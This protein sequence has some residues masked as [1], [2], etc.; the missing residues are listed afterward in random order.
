MDA[1]GF[2][3]GS[4]PD[5]QAP[6][7]GPRRG[8]GRVVPGFAAA[9]AVLDDEDFNDPHDPDT[10]IEDPENILVDD[11]PSAHPRGLA[12]PAVTGVVVAVGEA[13]AWVGRGDGLW[14]LP[15]SGGAERIALPSAGAVRQLASSADGRVIVAAL[16]GAIVRSDDGGARFEPV[17]DAPAGVSRLVV[18]GGGRAYALAGDE[19]SRLA[20]GPGDRA[21]VLHH[22]ADVTA[23]GDGALLLVNGRLTIMPDAPASSIAGRD[24]QG[25]DRP[26]DASPA[27]PPGADRLACSPEGGTWVAYGSALWVSEDRGRSWR[28]REDVNPAFP[29]AAVAVTHLSLW[30]GGRAGLATLPLR[31]APAAGAAPRPGFMSAEV[32]EA[33]LPHRRWW[34]PALP[35]IDLGFAMARSNSRRD[36]RAFVLLSFSFDPGRDARAERR[37][38]AAARA[39]QRWQVAGR[40][41]AGATDP[42]AL[43]PVVIEEREATSRL[44]D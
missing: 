3:V 33:A 26:D 25:D 20:I 43:D 39:S 35:R 44:L 34:L 40:Q 28:V 30:V 9:A 10:E 15:F 32:A 29:I 17:A 6:R 24:N 12:L 13:S 21:V 4:L 8:P 23:C 36:V 11:D 42:S 27:L 22:V 18:T 41:Q 2:P 19:L 7:S 5:L 1:T 37:V 38:A 14:R 31:T 16:D